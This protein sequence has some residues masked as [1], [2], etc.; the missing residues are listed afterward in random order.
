M[1]KLL[2]LIMTAILAVGALFVILGI[3][4]GGMADVVQKAIKI[5]T[6]CIGLGWYEKYVFK[7]KKLVDKSRSH[8]E[9]AHTALLCSAL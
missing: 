5:C 8:K 9:K 7:D 1:K 2:T 6:E 4:N 3:A